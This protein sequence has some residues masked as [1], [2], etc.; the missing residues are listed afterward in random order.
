VHLRLSDDTPHDR[1]T[2]ICEH[3]AWRNS[4]QHG[5]RPIVDETALVE[6]YPRPNRRAGL[7]VFSAERCRR[8]I[9]SRG[10]RMSS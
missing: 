7:D 10:C 1:R 6:R 2:R 8:P 9:R 3:E 4:D 5:A